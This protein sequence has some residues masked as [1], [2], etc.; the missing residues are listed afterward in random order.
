MEWDSV[1][2]TSCVDPLFLYHLSTV[3]QND[4]LSAHCLALTMKH[5]LHILSGIVT[6]FHR[7]Y[8]E[9]AVCAHSSQAYCVPSSAGVTRDKANGAVIFRELNSLTEGT[10]SHTGNM[11][12]IEGT[13]MAHP[14][15]PHPVPWIGVPSEGTC[16]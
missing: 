8:L 10:G 7:L 13:H 4:L 16:C 12:C 9:M 11:K 6:I 5:G 14:Q 3:F 1:V 15:T 2:L